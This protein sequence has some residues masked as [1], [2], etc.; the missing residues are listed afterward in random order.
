MSQSLKD[1]EAQESML[2]SQN[3]NKAFTNLFQKV[4]II[5]VVNNF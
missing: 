4:I 1:D 2:K 5:E 3:E